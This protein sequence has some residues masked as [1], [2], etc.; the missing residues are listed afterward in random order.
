MVNPT[1]D[2]TPIAVLLRDSETFSPA[3]GNVIKAFVSASSSEDVNIN[4]TSGKGSEEIFS[5]GQEVNGVEMVLTDQVTI[6]SGG[7]SQ[8]DGV[9]ISGF[10]VN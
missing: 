6:E 2:N 1:I 7:N 8:T 10:V 5:T 3:S 9:Y 4:K